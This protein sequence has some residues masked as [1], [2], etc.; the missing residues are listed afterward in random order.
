LSAPRKPE[1]SPMADID[2]AVRVFGDFY[3]YRE[4]PAAFDKQ[5]WNRLE[6][7]LVKEEVWFPAP[8]T[9]NDPYD[10][11]PH[12]DTLG[13]PEEVRQ[14]AEDLLVEIQRGRGD[15]ITPAIRRRPS[16]QQAVSELVEGLRVRNYRLRTLLEVIDQN[17]GV[18]CM[19]RRNNSILQWSYYGG[20][21]SGLCLE[22]SVSKASKPPF[23]QVVAVEYVNDRVSFDLFDVIGPNNRN[24]LWPM[25]RKKFR[26]WD[27]EEEVRAFVPTPGLRKF[28]P[29]ALTGIVFGTKTTDANKA[30]VQERIDKGGIKVKYYQAIQ[31]F[32]HFE[33]EVRPA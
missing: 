21:H 7:T 14:K 6:D 3:K 9:L 12:I 33:L 25:V 4:F 5:A 26:D 11:S 15:V 27:H 24:V 30:W 20:G 28:V 23:D 32:T 10:C 13:T 8:G 16:F 29:H 22:F 2:D 17:T 18:Y 1:G 31:S 19:S